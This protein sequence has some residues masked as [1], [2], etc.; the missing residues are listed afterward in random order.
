[1]KGKTKRILV[2]V[3]KRAPSCKWPIEN[4]LMESL[5]GEVVVV[6]VEGVGEEVP[7][8][9]F[10]KNDSEIVPS[11][12]SRKWDNMQMILGIKNYYQKKKK[13]M[14]KKHFFFLKYHCLEIIDMIKGAP[15][16]PCQYTLPSHLLP[17]LVRSHPGW[18]HAMLLVALRRGAL[19]DTGPS[20]SEGDYKCTSFLT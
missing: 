16:F 10:V 13:E 3:A 8:N 12:G 15:P 19:R 11:R 20:G 18:S 7:A 17:S 6:V 2:L 1:M 4:M 5:L 14:R 9:K